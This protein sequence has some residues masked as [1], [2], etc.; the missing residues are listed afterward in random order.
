M[1]GTGHAS[2]DRESLGTED[3]APYPAEGY[4]WYAV[5]VLML[6]NVS[7]YVDRQ[8]L[9]YLVDPIRR[10]LAISD[11]Q[12]SFLY[13]LSFALFYTVLGFPIG[14]L[15]DRRSRRGIIA[16][17]IAVW[18]AMTVLFG[19]GR[20]YT[21]LLLAR[22]GVGVGEAAL[23]PP[24]LSLI[25]DL[26]PRDRQA[27][28]VSVYGIGIYLGS[29]L[30]YLIGGQLVQ[31]VSGV[32]PWTL[33]LVGTI[34]PWQTVFLVIGLPGLLIAALMLTVREPR[35]RGASPSGQAI[36]LGEIARYVRQ[37]LPTFG[38]H[39]FGYAFFT[40]VNIGTAAWLPSYLSRVHGW[41][42]G[43]AGLFM[44]SATM[45]FGVGG[46]VF[47]GRLAD[48]LLRRG[49]AD[50][51]LRVGVIASLGALVSAIPLYLTR[52]EGWVIAL[53]IPLNVFS[54]FPFGAAQAALQEIT[55]SPMRAQVT[56]M[57]FFANSLVGTALGPSAV[58]V[59][60]DFVF[61]DDLAV[62]N[63]ILLVAVI[64]HLTVMTLLT[65]GGRSYGR[66]VEAR[67]IWEGKRGRVVDN[68]SPD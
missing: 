22:I 67:R 43:K 54:A 42:P 51:K 46:I 56:A 30:A 59:A 35:R 66:T 20:T 21:H 4:A 25:A 38:T 8:I 29:G 7:S 9:S 23:A 45:I 68:P 50:A 10:D 48:W 19:L 5:F 44:G 52:S 11:T 1:S 12:V 55:P 31:L 60:T 33:P 37:H 61:H 40:M 24:A 27:T 62:G 13:G 36:P 16:W 63:S 32:E 18:S 34:R 53:L 26:F 64:G 39:T 58:A 15:A 2:L 41:S 49:Y 14:R 6:A 47:G 28:A 17:G 3:D 65:L 57:Y